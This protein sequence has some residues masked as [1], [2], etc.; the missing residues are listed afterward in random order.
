MG[1]IILNSAACVLLFWPPRHQLIREDP[2]AHYVERDAEGYWEADLANKIHR[3]WR[4]YF[5]RNPLHKRGYFELSTEQ[6]VSGLQR[7]GLPVWLCARGW[8]VVALLARLGL[9]HNG[10]RDARAQVD[11]LY[12]LCDWRIHDCPVLRETMRTMVRQAAASRA[13]NHFRG[14][15]RPVVVAGSCV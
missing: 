13:W 15:L 8:C 9:T 6:R 1:S 11:V 7:V 14:S 10:M 12:A 5:P 2:A 4:Q 3:L